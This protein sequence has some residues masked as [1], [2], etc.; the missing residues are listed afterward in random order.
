MQS[1][2]WLEYIG[3]DDQ[4]I[5]CKL[6]LR[7]KSSGKMIFVDNLGRKVIELRSVELAERIVDGNAAILDFGVAF[8]STLSGLINERSERIHH[9]EPD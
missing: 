4:R 1:G 9:D 7:L 2:G 8:D 3:A 5:S 6:G